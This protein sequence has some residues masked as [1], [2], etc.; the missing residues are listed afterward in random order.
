ME[1]NKKYRNK[2]PREYVMT[3]SLGDDSDL[4]YRS[5]N[6]GQNVRSEDIY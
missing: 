3:T 5:R 6:D 4:Q 2:Y 1:N